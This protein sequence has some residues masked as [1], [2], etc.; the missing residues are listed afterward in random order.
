M[1]ASGIAA[2]A[3]VVGGMAVSTASAEDAAPEEETGP[4][5]P[6]AV[7]A[8]WDEET[9]VLVVGA[10]GGLAAAVR[11][12]E[13]GARVILIDKMSE[14]G[15]SSKEASAWV[16]PGTKVQEALG[17]P[18]LSDALVASVAETAP[19]GA[20][21]MAYT[22]N[23][24]GAAK[25]LVN[26]T[27]DAGFA[28]QPCTV[29]GDPGPVAIAPAGSEEGG[30]TAR[31]LMY[32]YNFMAEQYQANGGDLRL[33]TCLEGLV[34]E[35]GAVVGAKATNED[36]DPVWI[37]ANTGVLLATGG[38]GASRAMVKRYVPT[39]DEVC[40]FSSSGAQDTGEG[41]R[42]GLGAGAQF[43]GFDVF[44]QFDGGID[45][46]DWNAYMYASAVQMARQ[47]WLGITRYGERYPYIPGGGS[48][49]Y[50]AAAEQLNA[51]P[52]HEGFVFF[53]AK[54]AEYG[55]TFKQ[56]MCRRL[57][58]ANTM[59]D[60]GRVPEVFANSVWY[61]G[62]AEAIESGLIPSADTIEELAEKL[63]L[64]PTKV[65]AAVENW[66]ELCAQGTD[67]EGKMPDEFL[68]P[69]VEPPF[70]GMALGAMTFATH[71]GLSV[72]AYGQAFDTQGNT[73]PGLYA[74]GCAV[75]LPLSQA[76]GSCCFA[77]A[78]AYLAAE[79]MLG[80]VEA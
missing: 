70:C 53:D 65:I 77:A 3:S 16:A 78:S 55:P 40:K 26:W 44:D 48:S 64:D 11:A 19:F 6:L 61:E 76:N 72:D 30:M 7:P 25:R 49:A 51:L 27:V 29:T 33:W 9:D 8:A 36:G 15:G 13:L 71:A 63:G 28:W 45:G 37:K 39:C 10:G 2:G 1:A 60:A 32:V 5:E 74:S 43:D 67:P 20:H 59:P 12:Q 42:M 58:D 46:L 17:M 68:Y 38:M 22:A 54:Y 69:I 80:A 24:M 52:G 62:V 4:I 34:V 41:I 73:I 50:I 18:D 23:V 56:G 31:A 66:N 14:I 79:G 35:N 75:G 47:P 21:Y 57:I